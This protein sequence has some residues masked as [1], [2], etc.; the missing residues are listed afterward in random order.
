LAGTFRRERWDVS[1]DGEETHITKLRKTRSTE[2]DGRKTSKGQEGRRLRSKSA[3]R[4]SEG[5]L[6]QPLKEPVNTTRLGRRL[7]ASANGKS[8]TLRGN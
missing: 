7:R 5:R 6:F 1:V 4:R 2:E 8:L 3:K